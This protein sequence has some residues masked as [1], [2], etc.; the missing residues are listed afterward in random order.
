MDVTIERAGARGGWPVYLPWTS[1]V[2]TTLGGTVPLDLDGGGAEVLFGLERLNLVPPN[3][4]ANGVGAVKRDGTPFVTTLLG[5]ANNQ[6][7]DRLAASPAFQRQAG[8]SPSVPVFAGSETGG[9]L[10]LW[11]A[12]GADLLGSRPVVPARTAPVIW[13]SS[14]AGADRILFGGVGGLFAVQVPGDVVFRSEPSVLAGVLPSG[15]PG[16]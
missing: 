5:S 4:R 8:D 9:L 2:T 3:S 7:V 15:R 12:S 13:P 6:L 16:R 10:H 11:D 1:E 14:D